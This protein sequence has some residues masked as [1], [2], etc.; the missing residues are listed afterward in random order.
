MSQREIDP[1]RVKRLRKA[2]YTC[3]EIGMIISRECRLLHQP[4]IQG[5]PCQHA[6]AQY[7]KEKRN[8]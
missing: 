2:G 5:P 3:R 1:V 4:V 6:L 8:A 7:E